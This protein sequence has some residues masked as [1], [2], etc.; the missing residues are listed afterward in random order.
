MVMTPDK[1]N[2]V[3]RLECL[4]CGSRCGVALN[5]VLLSG[6]NHKCNAGWEVGGITFVS[7]AKI[8]R[9]LKTPGK[10]KDWSR[11]KKQVKKAVNS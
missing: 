11:A 9:A 8:M 5:G 10:R 2:V 7:T 6:I 4:G 1:V 3:E